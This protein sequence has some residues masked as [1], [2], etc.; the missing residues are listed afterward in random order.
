[1]TW[2]NR[3]V[4]IGESL[5]GPIAHDI[6]W[7]QISSQNIIQLPKR[8]YNEAAEFIETFYELMKDSLYQKMALSSFPNGNPIEVEPVLCCFDFHV[9]NDQL[10]LIEANTNASG[11]LLAHI[12]NLSKNTSI[13]PPEQSILDLKRS[14]QQASGQTSPAIVIIDENIADQKMRAEFYLY[15]KIFTLWGWDCEIYDIAKKEFVTKNRNQKSILDFNFVYNRYCDFILQDKN[16]EYINNLY[17]SGKIKFSPNPKSYLLLADKARLV[18]LSQPEILHN[19]NLPQK[20]IQILNAHIPTTLPLHYWS[21]PEKLWE[22]RKNL[23]FKPQQ[24]YGSKQAYKGK[25]MSRKKFNEIIDQEF[26]AQRF[27]PPGEF[28]DPHGITWKYDLRFYCF[29]GKIHQFIARSYQGQLTN[30]NTPGGG[31][32]AVSFN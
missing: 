14:F 25:G 13:L 9:D 8:I 28:K 15:Q 18:E 16:Y 4:Q 3:L 23:F 21:D 32:T 31:F 12:V 5:Y 6:S 2:Q 29:A 20:M 22:E 11:F 17:Y 1:M 19:L 24:S 27:T 26:I 30:F 7:E 10:I